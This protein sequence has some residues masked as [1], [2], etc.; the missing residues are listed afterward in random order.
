MN[1][2]LTG[3]RGSGKS[4]VGAQLAKHL[5]W[6]WRDSDE[7]VQEIAGCSIAEIFA[8]EGESGFRD[9]ESRVLETLA[10][11][12]TQHVISLGG[13]AILRPHNRQLIRNSGRTV[14][15]TA[16]ADTLWQRIAADQH[17]ASNRPSLSSLPGKEEVEVLLNQRR[18]LYQEVADIQVP[19]DDLP[20]EAVCRRILEWVNQPLEPNR[21]NAPGQ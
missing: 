2:Y 4:V 3:Y 20:L 9:R 8:R 14:W 16:S 11:S 7:L 13:G 12:S 17:S 6:E 5:G 15:L 1:L 10:T 18:V 19:T 21:A